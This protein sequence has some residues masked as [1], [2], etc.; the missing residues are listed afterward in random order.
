VHWFA[1]QKTVPVD[2]DD[3]RRNMTA[4]ATKVVGTGPLLTCFFLAVLEELGLVSCGGYM[5]SLA[6]KTRGSLKVFHDLGLRTNK[7][8]HA[9]LAALHKR[10]GVTPIVVE[11]VACKAHVVNAGGLYF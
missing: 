4:A 10:E 1:A 6:G 9:Y 8:I 5:P 2:A 11:N 7:E 3:V